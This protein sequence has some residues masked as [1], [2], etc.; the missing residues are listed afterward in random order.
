MSAP[1]SS[2]LSPDGSASDGA[3]SSAVVPA[4]A[5]TGP[6]ASSSSSSSTTGRKRPKSAAVV[7]D[8][9]ALVSVVQ[10]DLKPNPL[11]MGQSGLSDSFYA[12]RPSVLSANASSSVGAVDMGGPSSR[13]T[14]SP[15]LPGESAQ[16]V[17]WEGGAAST[18]MM[19]ATSAVRGQQARQSSF[20]SSSIP[21]SSGREVEVDPLLKRSLVK[22]CVL[23]SSLSLKMIKR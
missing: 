19:A 18:S 9:S 17:S 11:S 20:A 4:T 12:V 22:S 16:A 5:G 6:V 8:S 1:R 23:P 3:S 15:A 21:S 14:T 10:Q 13:S 2:R 7:V